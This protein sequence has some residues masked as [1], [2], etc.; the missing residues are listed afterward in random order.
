V[1]AARAATFHV[2]AVPELIPT[3]RALPAHPHRHPPAQRRPPAPRSSAGHAAKDPH[4]TGVRVPIPPGHHN[5]HTMGVAT[6]TKPEEWRA[7]LMRQL[8]RSRLPQF[9][10]PSSA[11]RSA[12]PRVLVAQVGPAAGKNSF[13]V[14][15][16][17]PG[18]VKS[19]ASPTAT[20]SVGRGRVRLVG[21][22]VP[23]GR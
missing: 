12:R 15:N 6:T 2:F 5:P 3:G 21:G 16:R 18:P 11:M 9:R 13:A 17:S 10:P 22:R 8:R 7:V 1:T 14:S 4:P 23:V 19:R 20:R